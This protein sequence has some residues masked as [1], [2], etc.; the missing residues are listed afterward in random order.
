MK[1]AARHQLAGI[2]AALWIDL[3]LVVEK[4][5]HLVVGQEFQ[6]GNADAV[7]ARDHT[8]ELPGEGHDARD[9]LVGFLQHAVV[10]RIHRNI[11]MYVAVTRVHV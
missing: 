2:E 6:F 5:L 7:L 8:I 9:R 1:I 3:C 10:V 11:G 4:R